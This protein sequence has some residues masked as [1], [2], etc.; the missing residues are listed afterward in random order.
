[1]RTEAQAAYADT[2]LFVALLQGPVHPLHDDALGLF[3]R[4]ADGAL[5]LIVTPVIVA[6]VTHALRATFSWPRAEIARRVTALLEADGLRVI[7][8]PVVALALNIVAHRSIDFAD[9][10]LA[11]AAIEVGPPQVASFDRDFDRIDGVRRIAR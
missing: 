7:E 6:E 8:G 4:V 9:A 3:R 1:M 10:Y 2:N 5:T 11:A